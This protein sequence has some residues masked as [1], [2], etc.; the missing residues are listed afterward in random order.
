MAVQITI[1][2]VPD[3]TRDVLAARAAEVG[4][5]MQEYLRGELERLARRPAA[6]EWLTRVRERKTAAGTRIHSDEIL[7]NRDADRR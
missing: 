2:N 7:R 4:K 3:A 1:R 5:S 6:S